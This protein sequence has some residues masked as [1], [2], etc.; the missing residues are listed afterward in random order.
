VGGR[1]FFARH[2]PLIMFEIRVGDKVNENL[3]ALV[4]TIG[5]RLFRQ[6]GGAPILVPVDARQP[7]DGYEL[8]LFAA[9][10]D[11]VCVL[12]RE[13][14]LVDEIPAWVPNVDNCRIADAFWRSQKFAPLINLLD[15][16]STHEDSDYRNSLAAYAT[17]RAAD[18]P[19]ATRCAALAFALRGLRV[20]CA[21]VPTPGRLSTLARVA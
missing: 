11:R 9:K 14:F 21:R 1:N 18:Q 2:S 15:G 12:S 10:L 16:N 7:L 5:Y 8:N 19:V 6:L 13:G 4:P 3:R 17:W 20:A